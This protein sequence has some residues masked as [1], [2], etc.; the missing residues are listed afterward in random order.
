MSEKKT[1]PR[2]WLTEGREKLGLDRQAFGVKV[3]CSEKLIDI[4]E[5][6]N[7]IT[8]PHIAARIVHLIGGGAKRL[9]QLVHESH[10]A[11]KLP[12]APPLLED[13]DDEI[14][15]WCMQC[16]KAYV[17]SGA[18]QRFCSISCAGRYRYAQKELEGN[19]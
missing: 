4:L 5:D 18:G 8:H 16:G 7:G 3:G 15:R 17:P 1:E 14:E 9:N 10:R 2:A 13:A 19:R 6:G 12:P 11:K